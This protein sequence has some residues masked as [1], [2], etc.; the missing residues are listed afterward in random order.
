[1]QRY[2]K[3][4]PT[5]NIG[6]H[7]KFFLANKMISLTVIAKNHIFHVINVI[8]HLSFVIKGFPGHQVNRSFRLTHYKRKGWG[9]SGPILK[10]I[11][12]IY[13]NIEHFSPPIFHV[14]VVYANLNDLMTFRPDD[15]RIFHILV[16]FPKC[17]MT[18]DK[19]HKNMKNWI[20]EKTTL[21]VIWSFGH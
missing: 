8:C 14:F 21:W 10:Y 4:G 13:Y 6:G 3:I 16:I 2:Y 18:N 15:R 19:W 5:A 7:K 11:F 9:I 1:M 17:L 12:Y 20:Q